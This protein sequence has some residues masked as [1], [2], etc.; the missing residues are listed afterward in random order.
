MPSS[1][2]PSQSQPNRRGFLA[3]AAGGVGAAGLSPAVA[4]ARWRQELD[5]RGESPIRVVASG[6]GL[7]AVGLAYRE[8]VGGRDTADAVVA[9]VS[10][11][12]DDPKDMTVGYGGFP[13]EDGVVALDAAVMHGPT[14]G[15]GSVA[16]LEQIKNPSQVALRVMRRTDHVML[17]GEGA[18][19]F[20]VAHG[21]K[22]QDLLTDEAREAWLSWK[23]RL[24]DEDDWLPPTP[25]EDQVAGIPFAERPTGTIHCAAVNQAGDLSCVTTTSGLA[26]KLAGRVGDS[27]IIGAGL[28]CDNDV[29]ACG[30]TG[31]GEEA[32]RNACAFTGVE[33]MRG[34]MSPADA[35]QEV[36]RRVLSKAADRLT[37]G[38]GAPL[39]NLVVYLLRKDGEYASGVIHGDH[40]FCVA[41]DTGARRED[42]TALLA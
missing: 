7:G 14:A 3:A 25:S 22:K 32:I 9:G 2:Q 30:C 17:V 15:A 8:I 16:A 27:P 23:E 42:C 4:A 5:A 21:F 1:R 10:L 20:A 41:D 12:E 19:K 13:N 6:N 34:G 31:R 11:V 33:L 39:F 36:L 28:Y 35:A 18:L 40:K 24:S 37:G 29:G 38:D 26:F